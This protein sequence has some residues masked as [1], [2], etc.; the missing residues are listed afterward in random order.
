MSPLPLPFFQVGSPA[1]QSRMC[2]LNVCNGTCGFL[3]TVPSKSPLDALQ[4]VAATPGIDPVLLRLLL[5]AVGI[6]PTGSVIEF[7]TGEW[8]VVMGASKT[9]GAFDRPIVRLVTDR[10]G[11]VL[12]PPREIDLG[13]PSAGR[14]FPRIANVINPNQAR[15][16]VAGVFV[17]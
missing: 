17:A 4:A 14:V 9:P 13:A 15:F 10:K 3:A 12:N 1:C 8:G 6:I 11:R 2:G 16:N 7:E 5:N